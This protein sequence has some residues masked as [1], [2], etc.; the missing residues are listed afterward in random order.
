MTERTKKE[1][2]NAYRARLDNITWHVDFNRGIGNHQQSVHW[3]GQM[4][5]SIMERR[6][7]LMQ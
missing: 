2:E 1:G 5:R 6:E 3:W 4:A 7:G